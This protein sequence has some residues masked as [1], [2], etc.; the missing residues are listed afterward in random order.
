[1]TVTVPIFTEL[2]PT[3]QLFVMNSHTHFQENPTNGLVTTLQTDGLIDGKTW[4][5]HKM[6]SFH[7][8]KNA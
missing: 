3:Q 7:F 6:F 2:M 4:S 8:V 1:M 5:P